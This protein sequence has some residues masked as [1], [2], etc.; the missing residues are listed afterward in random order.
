MLQGTI[1]NFAI[2][3]IAPPIEA[4]SAAPATVPTGPATDPIAPPKNL[5]TEEPML[6][7]SDAVPRCADNLP[8]NTQQPPYK[9]Y[10]I[11]KVMKM[12]VMEL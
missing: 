9:R 10:K 8:V 6:L 4:P 3:A 5:P 1:I 7:L 11:L 2:P 12:N